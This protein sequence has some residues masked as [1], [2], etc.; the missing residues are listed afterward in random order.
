[1]TSVEEAI[2]AHL[3]ADSGVAAIVGDRVYL[4]Q[5]PQN[6]TYPAIRYQRISTIPLYTHQLGGSQ[7]TVGWC[8]FQFDGFCQGPSSG[9]QSDELARAILTALGK[10]NAYQFGQSPLVQ[11]PNFLITR[12]M[13]IEPGTQPPV[14]KARLDVKVWYRDQ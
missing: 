10:F 5:L 4:V 2:R 9:K 11:A 7:G 12:S 8:R 6:P 14:F 1:M 13:G 3:V